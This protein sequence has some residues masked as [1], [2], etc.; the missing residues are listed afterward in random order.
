M[1]ELLA[2]MID[3]QSGENVGFNRAQAGEKG[4]VSARKKMIK[5]SMRQIET[6]KRA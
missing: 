5:S 6:H 3:L 4:R 1:S 2:Q